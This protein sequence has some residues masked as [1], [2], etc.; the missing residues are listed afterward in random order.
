MLSFTSSRRVLSAL[1]LLALLLASACTT[2]ISTTTAPSLQTL[3]YASSQQA[4]QALDHEIAAAGLDSTKLN[5]IAARLIQILREPKTT[6]AARQAVCERLRAFPAET[7]IGGDNRALFLSMFADEKQLNNARLALDVVPGDAIDQLYLEALTHSTPTT[8]LA[9]IQTIGNRRI[10]AAVPALT[11]LLKASDA[12][13][14][15]A[16]EKA[17]GQIG[18][19]DSLAALSS[20][21]D[22]SSARVIEARLSGAHQLGGAE[23]TREFQAIADNMDAPANLRAAAFRG[24]LFAEPSTA[25]TRFLAAISGDDAT[26]KP[27]VIQAIASHPSRDLVSALSSQ[28][29]TWDAPTQAAVISALARRGDVAAIS[30]ISAATQHANPE[31]RAAAITALGM[32]PGNSDVAL[33]LARI[34]AGDNTDDAKL[35]RLSLSRL[36]GPDVADTVVAGATRGEQ[37]LRIVFLEQI[38]SRN[39][40]AS[41]PLLLATRAD[42]AEPVRSAALRALAEIA[43]PTEQQAI[44]DWAI[45]AT[46]PNEQARALRALASVTLR[47]QDVVQRSRPIT[48]AIE[49]AQLDVALRLLPVLPRI[50]GA[51]SAECA[52]RLAL[53]DD[54]AISNAAISTL[55]RWTDRAGLLPLVDVAEK[56]SRDAARTAAMQ[57]VVRY[58]ERSRDLPSADLT[59]IVARLVPVCREIETRT[60]LVYL[61]GRSSGTDALA[62]AKKFQADPA[63]AAVASDAAMIIESNRAGRLTVRASANERQIKNIIDG[64]PNTRWSVPATPGQWVEVDFK[65]A[66]P[67]REIVLDNNGETWGAPEKFEVYVTNDPNKPGEALVT[68]SGQSGK[69][70]IDLPPGT[71]GRYLIIRH[72]AQT[73]DSVWAIGELI[74]D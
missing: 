28:L 51:A 30:A 1:S 29:A 9:L 23:A 52:A 49:H 20:A 21:P 62:L 69:T 73:E 22:P 38:A 44:L 71:R 50:G 48:D 42:P 68:G 3:D 13:V 45:A 39:M 60:R 32:L 35:A 26:L 58:L 41:V 11:P 56:T 16:A 14:V 53:R 25:A 5:A 47:N 19:A 66:R 64:K 61:L 36:N 63:L 15:A 27:V 59:A 72:T 8:R 43:P 33:I 55:S 6:P 18:T 67:L 65:A 10:P 24:L 7:L 4:V 74:V 37:P 31:V 57:G 12:A 70:T 40:A 54:A 17:L 2:P 34:A 46:N